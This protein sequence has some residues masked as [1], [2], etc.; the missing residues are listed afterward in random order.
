MQELHGNPFGTHRVLEPVG[1]LPQPALRIDND[2]TKLYDNEILCDVKTLNVD[3]A[4]FTQ[5]K[6]EA[7]GDIEKIKEIMFGIV[8]R[9]GKHKNPVTG[10]G[11]MFIGTVRRIG[12][13]LKGKIDLN[14][15]DRI[16]S[17]VSLS[18]T[19]LKIEEILQVHKNID[20]VDIRGQAVLFESGIWAKLPDDMDDK[21]ALAVLDVAGAPAQ[22]ARLVRPG[23]RVLIIGASGKSGLL[24]A[25]VAKKYAGVTGQIIGTTTSDSGLEWLK[26][27]PFIDDAFKVD[28][29]DA[30]TTYEKVK[31]I[32]KG[33][34]ADVVISCVSRPDC[35]MGAILPCREDGTVYFFSM[36]TSFTKAALGAEGVGKDVT[37]LIGN[38]YTRD[39][40]KIA[41]EFVRESAYI[42]ETY[43]KKYI[44]K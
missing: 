25:Y 18:L 28:A 14:E 12:S 29:T 31:E 39:H 30:V 24:C 19:P 44:G 10:S 36:A 7:G 2:L 27:V 8:G 26:T 15:G 37:M 34:M 38:G 17:L 42:R 33:H 4:S 35:E 23:Q 1:V 20:Q 16:A 43:E 40:A 13:A 5:I 3:S 32:T 9:F 21:L 22:T 11:G 41:L 6:D